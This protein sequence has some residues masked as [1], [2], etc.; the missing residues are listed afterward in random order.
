M[1]AGVAVLV[2]C[3]ANNRARDVGIAPYLSSG[4][5]GIECGRIISRRLN[6]DRLRGCWIS[7]TDPVELKVGGETAL[8]NN[9]ARFHG[10]VAVEIEFDMHVRFNVDAASDIAGYVNIDVRLGCSNLIDR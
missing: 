2:E 9:I 3:L 4:A 8:V 5:R 6:I 10:D 7:R 1:P